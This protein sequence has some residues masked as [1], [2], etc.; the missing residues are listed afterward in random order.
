[1]CVYVACE[2]AWLAVWGKRVCRCVQ[3]EVAMCAWQVCVCGVQH[4]ACG[5]GA[6]WHGKGAVSGVWWR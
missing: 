3:G 4:S 1:V 2:K 5:R 6:A